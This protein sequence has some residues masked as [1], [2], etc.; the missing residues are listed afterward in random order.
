MDVLVW[1]L[2][3]AALAVAEIFTTTLF[4]LMFSAG[5]LAAAGAAALGAPAP[6]QAGVFVVV[7][8]LTLAAVRP[9]LRRHLNRRGP[10]A[11]GTDTM[12]GA[13]AVVVEQVG[14]GH[15]M[16]RIDGELWQAR[17]LEDSVYQPG[18]MVRIVDISEGAVVVWHDT[19]PS[20]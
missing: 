1:I 5:A 8:V 18:E 15:G 10:V 17:S 20:L 16:V 2:L 7:S 9:A 11:M 3:G 6:V 19:H 13:A 4:L 14:T 12:R